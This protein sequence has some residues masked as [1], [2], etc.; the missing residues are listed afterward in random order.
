MPRV[1]TSPQGLPRSP[2]R[3]PLTKSPGTSPGHKTKTK[4]A[5]PY[6]P[7]RRRHH[8]PSFLSSDPDSTPT[9]PHRGGGRAG[10]GTGPT[11]SE[12]DIGAGGGQ[13]VGKVTCDFCGKVEEEEATMPCCSRCLTARYGLFMACMRTL[14]V[15][16]GLYLCHARYRYCTEE[17]QTAAW[18]LGHK[19]VCVRRCKHARTHASM[20]AC[21]RL[22][23]SDW[24]PGCHACMRACDIHG[25]IQPLIHACTSRRVACR[26]MC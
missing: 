7:S 16:T 12:A 8:Q 3:S 23:T 19:D 22:C 6:S 4:P 15:D 14:S 9:T 11:G 25:M 2:T 17:C 21:V 18:N 10:A 1:P 24:P 13:G 5:S 26:R 20:H